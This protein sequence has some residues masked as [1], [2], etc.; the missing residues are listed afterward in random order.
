MYSDVIQRYEWHIG[1]AF[2]SKQFWRD[3]SA[4]KEALDLRFRSMNNDVDSVNYRRA[5]GGRRSRWK[6]HYN[7]H[8]I[9]TRNEFVKNG[10]N[11]PN[12]KTNKQ[13]F[14]NKTPRSRDSQHLSSRKW[15]QNFFVVVNE[16]DK[17]EADEYKVCFKKKKVP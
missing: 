17:R 10:N 14:R 13:T 3:P 8:P 15:G 9:R 11:I 4:T 7:D 1:S 6:K 12:S 2:E 5:K 16:G